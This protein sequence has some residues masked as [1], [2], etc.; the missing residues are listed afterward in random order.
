MNEAKQIRK[1]I[2]DITE[3]LRILNLCLE[4]QRQKCG[5]VVY[6]NEREA[7]KAAKMVNNILSEKYNRHSVISKTPYFCDACNGFH[8]THIR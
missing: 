4:E 2:K 5:K 8:I 3:E 7:K 1:R 6:P